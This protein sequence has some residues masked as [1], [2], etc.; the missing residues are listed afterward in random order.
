MVAFSKNGEL[1][2]RDT[3]QRKRKVTMSGPVEKESS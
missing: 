2:I 1:L 3:T